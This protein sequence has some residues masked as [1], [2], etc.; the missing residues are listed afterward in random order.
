MTFVYVSGAGTS[1]ASRTM[2]ARVKETEADLIGLPFRATYCLRPGVI[3]PMH[4]ERSGVASYRIFYRL[5]GPVLHA[6][7]QL[8]PR[9]LLTTETIGRAML[10]LAR[11]GWPRPILEAPAIYDVS[12]RDTP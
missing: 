12:R 4:G 1:P 10:S 8:A 3:L 7:R 11:E 2:W 6:V 5:A 9:H